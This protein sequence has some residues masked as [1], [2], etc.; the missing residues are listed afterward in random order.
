MPLKWRKQRISDEGFEAAG[1]FDV[2]NDG[3]LDIVSGSYW[4]EGPD[5]TTVHRI[6]D[7][8][9]SGD[10]YDDF[11]NIPLDIN[12]NGLLDYVTGGW[13]GKTLQWRENPGDPDREWPLHEIDACGSIE[14]P[15][16]WDVD[17]DGVVELVPNCPGGPLA[18]YKLVTDADGKGTGRFTRT[19][20]REEAQ[21]HGLGAG[22]IAGNGRVD[23][24]LRDGWLEAPERPL[25]QPWSWHPEFT[26][27]RSPSV[28]ILVADVNGDGLSDIIVGGAHEYGLDWWEQRREGDRRSW[29]RHPIDPFNSQYHDMKWIDI[30][31]DGQCELVT[32]KRYLAHCGRDPGAHDDFGAYYFKW[33]SESFAKQ[34]IDYGPLGETT[35]TGIN[36]ATADLTGNNL[37]DMVAPGKDGLTILYNQ[38]QE[39]ES[40]SDS[41]S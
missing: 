14:L 30:D 34:I 11:S 28:P 6:G 21:G 37:P 13:F 35:G 39:S 36:F 4:Y 24:V 38:G 25:E 26:L 3:I 22:D 32:G 2:N 8:M 20:I 1:V 15:C 10:Y 41:K 7:V 31:G 17:G 27:N 9:P 5:F 12:G 18:V 29:H 19:V 23:F 16:A 40:R 33:N